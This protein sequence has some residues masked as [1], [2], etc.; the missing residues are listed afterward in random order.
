MGLRSIIG[1][2][3]ILNSTF[4]NT[5]NGKGIKKK[6]NR[7]IWARIYSNKFVMYSLAGDNEFR[8]LIIDYCRK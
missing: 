4:K 1:A 6:A 3:G 8:D 7:H 5:E 2:Y